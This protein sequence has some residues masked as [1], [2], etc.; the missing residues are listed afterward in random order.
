MWTDDLESVGLYR[1]GSFAMNKKR[2]IAVRLSQ[3]TPKVSTDSARTD[4]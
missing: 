4:D 3:A 2:D 1:F